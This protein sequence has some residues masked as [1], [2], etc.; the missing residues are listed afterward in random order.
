MTCEKENDLRGVVPG[1][2]NPQ[3]K[4]DEQRVI[5]EW[6]NTPVQIDRYP[7]G[8]LTLPSGDKYRYNPGRRL[9]IRGEQ[10]MDDCESPW[11]ASTINAALTSLDEMA[12]AQ[13][14]FL[15]LDLALE[16]RQAGL[17]ED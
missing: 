4:S 11:A 10:V 6:E 5:S 7:G 12:Q 8:L 17:Y 2:E 9:T 1:T 3:A 13:L 15:S 16:L 14:G